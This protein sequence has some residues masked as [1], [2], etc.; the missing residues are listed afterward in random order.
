MSYFQAEFS[1]HLPAKD[2]QVLSYQTL[3]D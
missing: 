2:F 3:L 1:T